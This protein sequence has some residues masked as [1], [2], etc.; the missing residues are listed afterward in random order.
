LFPGLETLLET[1]EQLTTT[2]R[3][4]DREVER[5]CRQRYPETELLRQVPGVGAITALYYVLTIEDPSRFAK[6]R[7]LGAYLGLR[8]KQ[9]D[10]G[11]Q[12][13][14]LRITKAGDRLLRRLLVSAAHYILGPFGPDTDLRRAGLRM[15]ARGGSASKKRAIVAVARRL[16]V[17]LHRLWVTGEVYEP[18]RGQNAQAA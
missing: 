4:M 8:P 6:S 18:L 7:S 3:Q 2:I 17:V 9:R 15:T 1:I 10:S 16:A 14:Q 12:Q 5:L 11:D 13:P